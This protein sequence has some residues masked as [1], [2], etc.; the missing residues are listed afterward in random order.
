LLNGEESGFEEDNG[1][2]GSRKI[3]FYKTPHREAE[4]YVSSHPDGRKIAPKN[5]MFRDFFPTLGVA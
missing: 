5:L 4:L 3:D 2:M 1:S